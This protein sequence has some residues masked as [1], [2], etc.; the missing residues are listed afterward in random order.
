MAN[1][2]VE[3]TSAG[4]PW[5]V[6]LIGLLFLIGLVWLIAEL[7]RDDDPV[8]IAPVD[9]VTAT[10]GF[11]QDSARVSQAVG[12][13][14]AITTV[15]QLRE[16]RRAGDLYG[17]EVALNDVRVEAVPGDSSFF[18]VDPDAS[19]DARLLVVL[20]GLGESEPDPTP[21]EGS[22]GRYNVDASNNVDVYGRVD[23]FRGDE[24]AVTGANRDRLTPDSL[25][26]RATRLSAAS[27]D[28]SVQAQ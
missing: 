21:R 14:E 18:I 10:D 27:D 11:V 20:V 28:T 3:R 16:R 8:D 1:I 24:P 23:R 4:T 6:W 15:D 22:D 13:G 17:R 19:G 9:P 2:P 25:Y 26:I 12:A 5:W 7:L